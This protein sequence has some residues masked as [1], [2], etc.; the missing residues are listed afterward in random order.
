MNRKVKKIFT[1]TRV[2]ILL[3]FVVLAIVAR[4]PNP[5]KEGV[6]IRTVISNSSANLAGI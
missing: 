6:A 2:I 5:Y 3:V 4:H 1:N